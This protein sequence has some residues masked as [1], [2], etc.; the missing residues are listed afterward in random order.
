ML[1]VPEVKG[2]MHYS[3]AEVQYYYCQVFSFSLWQRERCPNK[4]RRYSDETKTRIISIT[5]HPVLVPVLR[6]VAFAVGGG[7]NKGRS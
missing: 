2:V 1:F 4:L 6:T 5:I 3:L 7:F